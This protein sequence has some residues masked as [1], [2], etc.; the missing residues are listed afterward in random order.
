[1]AAGACRPPGAA[2][3]VDPT[4]LSDAAKAVLAQR[5]PGPG[6]PD[7]PSHGVGERRAAPRGPPVLPRQMRYGA[8]RG[9][10]ASQTASTPKAPPRT[11]RC[12]RSHSGQFVRLCGDYVADDEA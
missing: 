12:R 2:R 3:N 5:K 9:V 10:S 1:M 11:Q 7:T 4:S 6:G 8:C